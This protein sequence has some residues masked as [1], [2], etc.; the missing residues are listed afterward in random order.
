MP[1]DE[2]I[3]KELTEG[4]TKEHHE[5]YSVFRNYVTHEANL[6]NFRLN[7]NLTIQG[8][9]FAAYTFTLQKAAE[10]KVTLLTHLASATPPNAAETI[11]HYAPGLNQLGAAMAGLAA[12]GWFVSVAVCV[13]VW[14]ARTSQMELQRRWWEL[15]EVYDPAHPS[16]NNDLAKGSHGPHLPGLVGGGHLHTFG[17]GMW[18]S[19]GLPFV[20][21]VGWP[22]LL[23]F[24][25]LTR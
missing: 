10:L 8:F 9:L 18:A 2:A 15:H 17:W 16:K 20:F 3:A 4:P 1:S 25:W 14:A 5:V 21:I 22:L 13:S 7:W 12:L 24:T 6:I 19:L 23:W 11:L